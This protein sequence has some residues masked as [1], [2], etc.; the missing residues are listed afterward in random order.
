MTSKVTKLFVSGHRP[1]TDLR[2]AIRRTD[3]RHVT[4]SHSGNFILTA[5]AHFMALRKQDGCLERNPT[6]RTHTDDLP[7]PVSYS[8]EQGCWRVNP[9]MCEGF[10]V[11]QDSCLRL[12]QLDVTSDLIESITS[13]N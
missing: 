8:G 11:I 6:N 5:N 3:W 9:Q 10:F 7:I 2:K 1:Y 12:C 13:P 4:R